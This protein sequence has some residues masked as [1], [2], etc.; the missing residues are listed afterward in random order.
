MLNLFCCI[1]C[2]SD[3]QY[4]YAITGVPVLWHMVMLKF[5]L[6]Y[7]GALAILQERIDLLGCVLRQGLSM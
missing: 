5:L 6:R 7:S 3:C 1:L 2:S 4:T